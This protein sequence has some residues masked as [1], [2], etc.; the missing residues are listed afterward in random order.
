M[1]TELYG[2]SASVG[3]S[4]LGTP[5]STDTNLVF[6]GT[7]SSGEIGVPIL[8][9]SWAD[10]V[11]KLGVAS[12]DGH[13]LTDACISAFSVC[14]LRNIYCI[15]VSHSTTFAAADYTAALLNISDLW[16]KYGIIANILCAPR[17][18]DATVISALVTAAKK[19]NGHFD[20]IVIYDAVQTDDQIDA[21]TGRPDLT[22]ITSALVKTSTDKI[23]I[24]HWGYAK[25][26]SGDIV[27]GAALRACR[28]ALSDAANNGKLP[29]RCSGNLP[30]DIQSAVCA[31]SSASGAIGGT[32]LSAIPGYNAE[33]RVL[34]S[35][36]IIDGEP[37]NGDGYLV[38]DLYNS[39]HEVVYHVEG[40]KTFENGEV[41]AFT[42]PADIALL[43]DDEAGIGFWAYSDPIFGNGFIDINAKEAE[44]TQLSADGI[45]SFLNIG[46]G[47]Y[48]TWGDHTAAFINGAIADESGRFDNYMRMMYHITNRFQRKYRGIIDDKLSLKLRGDILS[49]E[50]D[51][52]GLLVSQ[53]GLI[54]SPKC[55]FSETENST[56]TAQQ[57]QFYF[58]DVATVTPP[59]KYIDM[60]IIFTSEGFVVY[61]E[62]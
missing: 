25:L 55:Y 41:S 13:T 45:D 10:A 58:E 24:C 22:K 51:F 62:D 52:L 38:Y 54:G 7:S 8:I 26:R 2:I 46:G 59:A 37:Y 27:S 61:Q 21:S 28:L 53:E 1:A 35:N 12:G 36:C 31:N 56:E 50:N 47:Q 6:Y 40:W 48:V 4:R 5:V 44:L 3:Q 9:S 11:E 14:N 60:K 39:A 42:V 57:G 16:M 15:P 30:V 33:T 43:V 17:V 49:E 23:C 29:S 34:S 19:Q 20:G 18:Q 32:T